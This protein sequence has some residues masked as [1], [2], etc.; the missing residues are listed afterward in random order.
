MRIQP[1][2]VDAD[3]GW[4]KPT[5]Q[6]WSMPTG[7]VDVV[8]TERVNVVPTERVDTVPTGRVDAMPT[9]GGR[10]R[11]K[12]SMPT[13]RVDADQKVDR[14]GSDQKGRCDA[15]GRV[16]ADQG[17]SMPTGRVDAMPIKGGRCRPRLVDADQQGRSHGEFRHDR[18]SL[19][20]KQSE[21]RKKPEFRK[22][23][24]RRTVRGPTHPENT[25]TPKPRPED[26]ENTQEPKLPT[27]SETPEVGL[28]RKIFGNLDIRKKESQRPMRNRRPEWMSKTGSR[29]QAAE[30]AGKA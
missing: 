30:D 23:L 2:V 7:R 22:T 10:C 15:D 18:K 6:G 28:E 20:V 25:E 24:E 19:N 17:W 13:K 8:P 3:Q 16:N 4:L 5:N 26:A 11:P 1:R 9:K 12:G 27:R 29:N 21:L 14:C